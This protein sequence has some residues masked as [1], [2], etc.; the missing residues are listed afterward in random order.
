LV[1]AGATENL[2]DMF[3]QA[4]KRLSEAARKTEGIA[5]DVWQHCES[6]EIPIIASY[7]AHCIIMIIQFSRYLSI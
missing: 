1:A 4:G 5:G 2:R 6:P 7:I 3:G